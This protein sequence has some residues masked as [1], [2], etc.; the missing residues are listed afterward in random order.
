MQVSLEVTREPMLPFG[1]H[2]TGLVSAGRD[3]VYIASLLSLKQI[4]DAVV[5]L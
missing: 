4:G 2:R 3:R 1:F 5:P